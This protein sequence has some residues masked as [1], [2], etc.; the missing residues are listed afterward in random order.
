MAERNPESTR[1]RQAVDP[2]AE[3][4]ADGFENAHE[5]G[6]GKYGVV[7]SCFQR[8]LDRTVAVKVLA[9][10]LDDEH[11]EHF[12]HA[13]QDMG[14]LSDHPNIVSILQIGV[15][16][17]G[18]PYIVMPQHPQGSLDTRI[19]REGPVPLGETLDIGVK[20]AGALETAHRAGVVHQGVKPT[21]VIFSEYNEP[22]LTD[23]GIARV[24]DDVRPSTNFEAAPQTCTPPELIP[25][26]PPSVASDV[27]DLGALLLSALTGYA[28]LEQQSVEPSHIPPVQA[29]TVQG[30]DL[31]L[32]GLPEAVRKVIERAMAEDPAARHSSA[33]ELGDDLRNAQRTCG[34]TVGEMALPALARDRMAEQP[35]AIRPASRRQ[36]PRTRA[37]PHIAVT[38]FVGRKRLLSEARTTLAE[39]RLVTL[40]GPGGVGKTRIAYELAE[41]SRKT[42]RD[43][44]RIVELASVEDASRVA[45]AVVSALAVPDQSNREAIG[46][47]I[48]YL[49]D[50]QMLIVLDN[51]EH[52][53]RA[54]ATMVA[55]LLVEARGVRILA[56]SREPLSIAGEHIYVIPPLSTPPLDGPCTPDGIDHFEAVRLLID[57]ARSITP[58]FEVTER[59]ANAIVQLCNRL[60]GIPLAIELASARLRTLSVTQIV[61]RLDRRFQL[62]TSGDRVALPR[63]QTLR[64][65]IDWSYELCTE[66]EKVLWSRLS[67]FA[68]NFDL[69]AAEQV[70]GFGDLTPDVILDVLDRLVAKSILVTDRDGEIVR[71]RQLMTVREYGSEI[72]STSGD[73]ATVKRRH[74]D[75]YLDRAARMVET[76]CGPGQAEA[77][78]ETRRNHSNLISA[79]EWSTNTPEEL[80]SAAE[81]AALLRYHWIAGGFLSD[82]RRCLEEIL[83]AMVDPN[84][85]HGEAL[86][87][88]AWVA[89]IQGDR[90]SAAAWLAECDE[91]ARK[92]DDPR[93][94]TH[95][96]QWKAEH[97]LFSGDAAG[98]INLLE[99]A[100]TRHVEL[101]DLASQ[102]TTQFQLAMAQTYNG[103]HIEA[104][105][106]CRDALAL[107]NGQGE[108]WARSYALWISGVCHWHLEEFDRAQQDA[109]DA[110]SM[111]HDFKDS[112]CTALTIELLSWIAASTSN[113]D[114]AAELV[115]AAGA[116]WSR[117]GTSVEAFGPHLQRDSIESAKKAANV[118][119]NKR[120]TELSESHLKLDK[121]AAIDLAIG[122]A[123]TAGQRQPHESATPTSPLTKREHEIAALVSRGLSNRAIAESLVI[124]TRTVDG[125]V[126]RILAKLDFTSRT[127]IASWLASRT[128]LAGE[129]GPQR[130]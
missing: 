110:L 90:N 52:L 25:A 33:A 109:L 37:V 88:A 13:H 65:L 111:Q 92:N 11:L 41:R 97:H 54:A 48:D 31:N 86:W 28:Q 40:T 124:S 30:P 105:Q 10:G 125:H 79:L 38:S 64:A 19:R 91:L 101:G 20:L 81:L 121:D 93:L 17:T 130:T 26:E 112:I 18:R 115:A 32:D 9:P 103:H 127:Q 44:V 102:L 68:G 126:E 49:H 71:Y 47:L 76:W 4:E 15:T 12:V 51:C 56:T 98:A 129:D 94:A 61:E 23:F 78:A 53:L 59:N 108:R 119:G 85:Q 8:A 66:P 43:G 14:R 99:Q 113:F 60:D 22:Q 6:R 83:A 69:E 107:S 34:L 80:G 58:E 123:R 82:G 35:P 100:L 67:V 72:L 122:A 128:A 75:H 16:A 87:V 42:F 73:Y 27:Y 106:T 46:K 104:L 118:L 7:Y 89:L 5:V 50:R 77:L 3:L 74:R 24:C 29:D 120:M 63:Q 57:R 62:L 45:D 70:C 117:L 39:S 84:P 21:N 114:R 2:C 96:A 1:C 36:N 116:V 55:E 95:V